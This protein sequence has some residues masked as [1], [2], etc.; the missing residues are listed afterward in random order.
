SLLRRW[1]RAHRISFAPLVPPVV[2][3]LLPPVGVQLE[4]VRA[5]ENVLHKGWRNTVHAFTVTNDQVTRH[6]R[7]ATKSH[8]NIDARQHYIPYGRWV[9]SFEIS[10]HGNF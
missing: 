1:M 5:V 4:F 9:D 3:F 6:H 8:R 10:G 2:Q 7:H